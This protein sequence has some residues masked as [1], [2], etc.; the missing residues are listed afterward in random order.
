VDNK[1]LSTRSP[2]RLDVEKTLSDLVERFNLV[3]QGSKVCLWDFPVD[4][5]DPFNLRN[6]VYYSAPMQELLGYAPGEMPVE[7]ETWAALLHPDDRNRV[8]AA[9]QAHVFEGA[10]YEVDYRV[11]LRSGETLWLHAIGESVRDSR[12]RSTRMSGSLTDVTS[13]K[14]NEER[15]LQ[16]QDFL[17]GL[18][19]AHERSRQ[20]I[21]HELHDGLVQDIVAG[22]FHL[23]S[24]PAERVQGNQVDRDNLATSMRLARRAL[25]E[26]RRVLTGLRPPVLDKQGLVTAIE[27]LIAE[28]REPAVDVEFRHAVRFERLDSLLEATVFRIAQEALTNIRRHSQSPRAEIELVQS[29]GELRLSVRDWGVGFD[30]E[31][32]PADRFGLRGIGKRAALLGGW[33][34]I[35][36][37]PGAGT[38]VTVRFPMRSQPSS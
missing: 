7:L 27:H 30:P 20:L 38:C 5:V 31:T 35:D 8:F 25:A 37:A 13:H 18:L 24:I 10:P 23:D 6:P 28:D 26:A 14:R 3:V 17:R 15:L 16:E 34:E 4:P 32:V 21:A 12:G 22:L 19:Q 9:L 2:S 33:V 36:S 29:D 1:P 11:I